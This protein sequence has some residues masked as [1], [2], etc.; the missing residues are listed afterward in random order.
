MKL[1]QHRTQGPFTAGEDPYPPTQRHVNQ[2]AY[3]ET[4]KSIGFS[5][6]AVEHFIHF[7][8]HRRLD[9]RRGNPRKRGT[10][11]GKSSSRPVPT[12]AKADSHPLQLEYPS[13]SRAPPKP[14]TGLIG[15]AALS[16]W[17]RTARAAI[18]HPK[19]RLDAQVS[20]EATEVTAEQIALLEQ[21]L[22]PSYH[23][24]RNHS[25]LTFTFVED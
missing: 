10:T 11:D 7:L 25:C 8:S 22:A 12:Y 1:C 5:A 4:C 17:T 9:F 2:S 16:H 19:L 13:L 3:A 14:D 18:L 21:V 20:S 6:R 24:T 15:F 23:P